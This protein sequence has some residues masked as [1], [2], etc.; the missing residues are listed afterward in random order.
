VTDYGL[1]GPGIESRWGQDFL[2]VQ[3]GPGAHP[4]SC[5]MGT[6]YFPRV[7]C[8]W[9][10]L[11]TTHPLLAPRSWKSRTIPLPPSGPQL[12]LW[13]GY[14][15]FTFTT[16]KTRKTGL[17]LYCFTFCLIFLY[18]WGTWRNQLLWKS[19]HLGWLLFEI[20]NLKICIIW[21]NSPPH[22]SLE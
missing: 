7:K 5:T 20:L 8:D 13:Q 17:L 11:L 21:P 1:D 4:A 12:G 18:S 22:K 2:P 16:H 3:T 10:T 19:S 14:F 6:G 15:T 9:G